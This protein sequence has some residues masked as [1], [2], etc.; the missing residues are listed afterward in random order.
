M[1]PA[2]FIFHLYHHS[3]QMKVRLYAMGKFKEKIMQ[4]MKGR[5]GTDEL[6]LFFMGVIAISLIVGA[7]TEYSGRI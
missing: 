4:F 7:V 3:N 1:N 2:E 5:Y 6:S